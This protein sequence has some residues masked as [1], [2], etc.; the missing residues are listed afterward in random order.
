MAL[1]KLAS[2]VVSRLQ[3]LADRRAVS[4]RSL[5]AAGCSHNRQS[6]RPDLREP[7]PV[8]APCTNCGGSSR[9]P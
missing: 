1:H 9:A 5:T 6:Y 3:C 8:A 2:I 7:A 4:L